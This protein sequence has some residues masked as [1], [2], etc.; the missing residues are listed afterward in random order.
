M[1]L[2]QQNETLRGTDSDMWFLSSQHGLVERQRIMDAIYRS[3]CTWKHVG[4]AIV[5]LLNNDLLWQA[6]E[7]S[8]REEKPRVSRG[9]EALMLQLDQLEEDQ[10]DSSG[11]NAG[12][13]KKQIFGQRRSSQGDSGRLIPC[14]SCNGS[15]YLDAE[16]DSS[17]ESGSYLRKTLAQV[18]ELKVLLDQ[19]NSRLAHVENELQGT[20]AQ[21]AVTKEKLRVIEQ[22]RLHS[23]EFGTQADLDDEE[24]VSLDEIMNAFNDPG[25][26]RSRLRRKGHRQHEH[27]IV[28]LKS[29]LTE[30][31]IGL[32]EARTILADT[33]AR[34]LSL[35][36]KSQRD[37]EFHHQEATA[38]KT[39]LTLAMNNR[40]S[41]INEKQAAVK[42]L[43]KQ[44]DKQMQLQKQHI[45]QGSLSSIKISDEESDDEGEVNVLDG[46]PDPT[47]L[48]DGQDEI[49]RSE[50]VARRYTEAIVR[51]QKEYEDQQALLQYAEQEDNDEATSRKRTS[52][53]TLGNIVVTMASHPRDLFKALS[54]AKTEILHMRR[55]TQKSSTLQT[56]RLLTLTTHLGHISEEL[57]MVRKRTT[58]EI[59]YWRLECEKLQHLNKSITTN[60]HRAQSQL[61]TR[62]EHQSAFAGAKSCALC[63]KHQVRLM[64]MS[65]K[66]I[67]DSL[68][69]IPHHMSTGSSGGAVN[70]HEHEND[71]SQASADRLS[72]SERTGLSV[73]MLELES[74]YATLSKSKQEYARSLLMQ[75][76]LSF[77][78]N[79][80]VNS[81]T[82]QG[83]SSSSFNTDKR[84]KHDT[85]N[86]SNSSSAFEIA[87]QNR[88]SKSRLSSR[89]SQSTVRIENSKIDEPG[90]NQVYADTSI[91]KQVSY[92]S[93]SFD[94]LSPSLRLSVASKD[95]DID[96]YNNSVDDLD[97]RGK[98]YYM[99]RTDL[100]PTHQKKKVVRKIL[101]EEEVLQRRRARRQTLNYANSVTDSLNESQQQP[102]LSQEIGILEGVE[103]AA[104]GFVSTYVDSDGREIHYTEE[105]V[106]DDEDADQA[107]ER[108]ER[109]IPEHFDNQ[110]TAEYITPIEEPSSTHA[111]H[112][113]I[114]NAEDSDDRSQS[115]M[116]TSH[117]FAVLNDY[118]SIGRDP[119]VFLDLQGLVKQST[120]MKESM[121]LMNWTILISHVRTRR[122]QKRLEQVK[123]KSRVIFSM[124]NYRLRLIMFQIDRE[125]KRVLPTVDGP[126]S[127]FLVVR[128]TMQKLVEYREMFLDASIQARNQLRT[129]MRKLHAH[130][131]WLH[132]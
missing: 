74:V 59:E 131:S 3:K 60:L 35:Q 90:I 123:K 104:E 49:Q 118:T 130:V 55:A 80:G 57:C 124:Y 85:E 61:Q 114:I 91:T 110:S 22:T 111:L 6:V 25:N 77:D 18:L 30:K 76:L 10:Q 78:G 101:S 120:S 98:Q 102:E 17:G 117:S 13:T 32:I 26:S 39:S 75:A 2:K 72:E 21:A 86:T 44:I 28:E 122:D 5:E 16:N 103:N 121:A 129:D 12:A 108:N 63:E 41:A 99:Q 125:S 45:N 119:Q 36:R 82:K 73:A 89:L 50:T 126:E 95:G 81:S 37:Q 11:Q 127:S 27:L 54:T 33:Q 88:R 64:E 97:V 40:S 31:E 20:H 65:N 29:S 56:D 84:R 38:L 105:E 96:L 1:V 109:T 9:L 46:F 68:E 128:S 14:E 42:L 112:T 67:S 92:M 116:D 106:D 79:V 70:E 8:I 100:S 19:A 83:L 115:P 53:I 15:G 107:R 113:D 24:P 66:L 51:V 23:V 58:A 48:G 7:D 69:A 34:L 94:N 71:A 62:S 47:A 52:S 132:V 4:E 43:L 93:P 87:M